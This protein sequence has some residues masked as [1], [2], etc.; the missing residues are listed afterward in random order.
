MR[1]RPRLISCSRRLPIF[2]LG[3]LQAFL[4]SPPYTRQA[5]GAVADRR[6]ASRN[7]SR[8]LCYQRSSGHPK[9]RAHECPFRG[10]I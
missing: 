4:D 2:V 9:H 7:C 5:V 3:A 1:L 6:S 8:R 10:I